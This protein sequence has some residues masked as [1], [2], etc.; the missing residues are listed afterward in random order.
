M[1]AC[2]DARLQVMMVNVSCNIIIQQNYLRAF[3]LSVETVSCSRYFNSVKSQ[4]GSKKCSSPSPALRLF[5][6]N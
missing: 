2:V 4:H 3:A 6:R 1:H 5:S